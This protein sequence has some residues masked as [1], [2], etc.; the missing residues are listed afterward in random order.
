MSI[1]NSYNTTIYRHIIDFIVVISPF[2]SICSFTFVYVSTVGF[3]NDLSGDSLFRQT[4]AKLTPI[5]EVERDLLARLV[6]WSRQ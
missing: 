3:V 2:S 5:G 6:R 4:V 1:K